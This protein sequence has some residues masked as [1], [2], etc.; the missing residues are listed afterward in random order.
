MT[1]ASSATHLSDITKRQPK[2][3]KDSNN[4]TPKGTSGGRFDVSRQ[5]PSQSTLVNAEHAADD[6]RRREYRNR[7][8]YVMNEHIRAGRAVEE[9]DLTDAKVADIVVPVANADGTMGFVGRPEFADAEILVV[10]HWNTCSD[11]ALTLMEKIEEDVESYRDA[12]PK[13]KRFQWVH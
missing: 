6:G 4:G 7:V 13:L 1:P 11:D 12:F 9:F 2:R 5:E 3:L 8:G 10:T